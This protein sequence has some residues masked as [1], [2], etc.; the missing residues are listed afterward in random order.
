MRRR[1]FIALFSGA[2]VWSFSAH[3]QQRGRV[4]RIGVLWHAANAEQ[5][6]IYLGALEKGLTDLGYVAGRTITL[7]HRFPNEQPD[8]FASL[9]A[10]LVA[11]KV[12]VLIAVTPLAALAAQRATTTIPIVFILVPDPVERKLVNS[13]ARPGGNITGLTHISI[14]L[15]AKRLEMLKEAFPRTTRV[16][17]LLNANDQ[18]GTRR[19]ISESK[20]AATALGLDVQ[21]M[22]LRSVEDIEQVFDKI[23]EARLEIVA[24]APDGLMFQ[25]RHLIAQ[26]AMTR[27]LPLIVFSRETLMAGGLMSYGPD[28]PAIFRRAA[29]YVDK[30]LKGE[31][32]SDL[33]VEQPTKFEFLINLNTARALGLEIS[34]MLLSR[35]DDVIE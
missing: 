1:E 22:E 19:Y 20:T 34:P 6:A 16:A 5:E 10:E 13:L 8:R 21:P 24:A 17:L 7:E 29:T 18:S 33:P 15:S 26:A 27:H 23:V 14:D 28:L 30:L 25:G 9:A 2:A 12:D 3:A 4:P 35:A 31:T 11:L 32:P